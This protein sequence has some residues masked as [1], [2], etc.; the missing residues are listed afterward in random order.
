MVVSSGADQATGCWLTGCKLVLVS[1]CGRDNVSAFT[2]FTWFPCLVLTTAQWGACTLSV[3]DEIAEGIVH[4][5]S[6]GTKHH[7]SPF[8]RAF[9]LGS[10]SSLAMLYGCWGH[11]P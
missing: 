9:P 7:D 10:Y 3:K 6:L 5:E 8:C 4:P 1:E 2:A 11:V